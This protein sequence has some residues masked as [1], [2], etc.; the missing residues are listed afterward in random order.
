MRER[1]RICEDAGDKMKALQL[2]GWPESE[3]FFSLFTSL[4]LRLILNR[5]F[6]SANLDASLG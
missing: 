5:A 4:T 6:A 2:F 1:E 3:Y